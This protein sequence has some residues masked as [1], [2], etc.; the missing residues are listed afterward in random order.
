MFVY[1]SCSQNATTVRQYDRRS[2]FIVVTTVIIIS[3]ISSRNGSSTKLHEKLRYRE[4][5]SASVVLSWCTL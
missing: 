3:S 2:K 4:E 1:Y 5:H